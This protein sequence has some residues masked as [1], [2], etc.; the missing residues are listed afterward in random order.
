MS[1][2]NSVIASRWAPR[3]DSDLPVIG[4]IPTAANVFSQSAPTG[5]PLD[6]V[7]VQNVNTPFAT[8][9]IGSNIPVPTNPPR[10]IIQS[11]VWGN[12][13]GSTVANPKWSWTNAGGVA[14]TITVKFYGDGTANPT[15]LLATVTGDNTLTS[16]GYT[17]AT[18]ANNYYKIVI[19]GTNVIGTSTPVTDTQQNILPAPTVTLSSKYFTGSVGGTSALPT[20]NWSYG[21]GVADSYSWEFQIDGVAT[22]TG[23]TGITSYTYYSP[24]VFNK[25]YAFVFTATN[26]AGS[27]SIGYPDTDLPNA[28]SPGVSISSQSIGTGTLASP[29]VT[30]IV[31]S[32]GNTNIQLLQSK[33]TT[34]PG[35]TVSGYTILAFLNISLPSDG[36]LTRTFS[37]TP[38][39]I[40]RYYRFRISNANV[41]DTVQVL[42]ST[43][44]L[45]STG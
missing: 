8:S 36:S 6:I 12:G 37:S 31:S 30:A 33:T 24:T 25:T 20:W 7:H 45:C 29:S 2:I 17:G 27:A 9:I 28:L 1:S 14:N 42:S 19:T 3:S 4:F 32:S 44:L 34:D 38:T 10:F 43:S 16:A 18:V 23:T 22:I 13:V 26:T 11:F 41:A 5:N 40:G 15:T 39:I 35:S 21:G